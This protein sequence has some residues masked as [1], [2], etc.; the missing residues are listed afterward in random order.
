MTRI[1]VC[2]GAVPGGN[3][4]AGDLVAEVCS[5]WGVGGRGREGKGR[6]ISMALACIR[7]LALIFNPT[8]LSLESI[9]THRSS[10]SLYM[11]IRKYFYLPLA[12]LLM[13]PTEYNMHSSVWLH[14]W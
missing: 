14:C 11:V 13:P 10:G 9:E 4:S 5:R 3:A 7:I 1:V 8:F 12:G 2:T 6:W